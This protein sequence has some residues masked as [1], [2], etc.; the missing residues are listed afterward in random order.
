VHRDRRVTV[1]A[2]I[3]RIP[4]TVEGAHP[5]IIFDARIKIDHGV[6][7]D[8]GGRVGDYRKRDLI[9]R[10]LNLKPGLICGIISPGED[11]FL[12]ENGGGSQPAGCLRLAGTHRTPDQLNQRNCPPKTILRSNL[13]GYNTTFWEINWKKLHLTA[14]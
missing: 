14:I 1:G 7:E 3:R 2:G 5:E 13:R 10:L 6:V 9:Q 12:R 8:V 4:G 11:D